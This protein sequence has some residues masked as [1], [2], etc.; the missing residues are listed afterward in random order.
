TAQI[1]VGDAID[2]IVD[3]ANDLQQV[4]W[5]WETTS[6]ADA[7]WHFR[8]SFTSHWGAHLRALQL[9]LHERAHWPS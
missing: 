5:R 6:E 8:F 2:D 9:Y 4:V 1:M 7:L 3:I